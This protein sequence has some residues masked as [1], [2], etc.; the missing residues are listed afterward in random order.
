VGPGQARRVTQRIVAIA[1]L[2]SDLWI[3]CENRRNLGRHASTCSRRKPSARQGSWITP[4]GAHLYDIY[5]SRWVMASQSSVWWQLLE[6]FRRKVRYFNTF[7]ANIA[8]IV[9]THQA[10]LDFIRHEKLMENAAKVGLCVRDLMTYA[11]SRYEPDGDI[12][13]PGLF[14][15]VDFVKDRDSKE[16]DGEL[17]LAVVDGLR[18][19]SVLI[20][21]S[22]TA[23]AT[24]YTN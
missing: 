7:G 17:A 23:W 4:D 1:V 10:V 20:R 2:R 5:G 3:Q 6:D 14:I 13:G 15:G 22:L 18:E 8:S 16:P 24:H 12:L 9:A 11:L 21:A 19:K